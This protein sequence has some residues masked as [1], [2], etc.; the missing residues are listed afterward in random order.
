MKKILAATLLALSCSTVFAADVP[1]PSIDPAFT[2]VQELIKA[3]NYT[4]AYQEL[5][6]IGKTGNAQALYN[7]GFLTQMGQ[8]TPKDDKKALKY[9]QESASKGY[10]VANYILAQSYATGSLGLAKDDKKAREYLEKASA[11]GFE[12]ASVELAVL[13]FSENK[14]ESDKKG[15]QKLEPLIKKGNFQAIHAKALYDI[16]AGY[17][18]KNEA[19]IKQ[20]LN[21]IQELAKKGYIPALMAVANM[22]TNGNIVEQNL[23]E[24]KNIYTALAKDNVPRAKESL[25]LVNKLIAEKAKA[26]T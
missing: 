17:K 7:L 12:D 4:E 13:L 22:M 11:Q 9:Y 26:P 1:K 14:P 8:G 15:L 16:T 5:D 18:T 6:K 19:S 10:S 25:E 20:G 23:T 24:A 2:K 3:K 21:A